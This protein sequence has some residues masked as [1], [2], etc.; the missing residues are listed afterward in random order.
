MSDQPIFNYDSPFPLLPLRGG[1][2]EFEGRSL[3]RPGV[4]DRVAMGLRLLP[5]GRGI[6]PDLSVEENIDVVAARNVE[7]GAMFDIPDVY[8]LFPV[9]DE[10]RDTRSGSLPFQ[11]GYKKLSHLSDRFSVLMSRRVQKQRRVM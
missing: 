3:G 8:K 7:P 11:M 9:L 5:E 1:S 10:R 6:F 2:V 4:A